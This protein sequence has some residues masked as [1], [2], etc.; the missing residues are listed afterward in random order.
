MKYGKKKFFQFVL[1]ILRNEK[2]EDEE[3]E[4]KFQFVM[5]T[6]NGKTRLPVFNIQDVRLYPD[7]IFT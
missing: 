5:Y 4:K 3:K 6:T 7:M 2:R 1:Y